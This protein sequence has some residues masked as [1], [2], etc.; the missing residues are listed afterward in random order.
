MSVGALTCMRLTGHENR[1]E[2]AECV[3]SETMP[4][5]QVLMSIAVERV[6][7]AQQMPD[8]MCR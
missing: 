4:V 1:R 3:T 6:L 7:A 8:A 5:V 2:N